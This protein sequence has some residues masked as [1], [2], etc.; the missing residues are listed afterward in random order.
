M[1]WNQLQDS[2]AVAPSRV[3]LDFADKPPKHFCSKEGEA[4]EP[5][6]LSEAALSNVPDL[7]WTPAAQIQGLRVPERPRGC[8]LL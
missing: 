4:E 1:G 7:G 8:S 3:Q 2:N 6:A 5:R